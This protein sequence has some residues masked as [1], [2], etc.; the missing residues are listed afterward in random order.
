MQLDV[1]ANTPI[2]ALTL[3]NFLNKNPGKAPEP[4]CASF[5]FGLQCLLNAKFCDFNKSLF[6]KVKLLR[7]NE[8]GSFKN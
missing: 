5:Q 2:G 1:E 6:I 8:A 3:I 7:T 4:T